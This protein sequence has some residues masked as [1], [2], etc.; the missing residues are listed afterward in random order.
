MG[1]TINALSLL[2]IVIWKLGPTR[3]PSLEFLFLIKLT[4]KHDSP[5]Q[6]PVTHQGLS[7]KL[8]TDAGWVA[9]R[10]A[11]R[12]GVL[13]KFSSVPAPRYIPPP[14]RGRYVT[15]LHS[16]APLRATDLIKNYKLIFCFPYLILCL[17]E[18][19]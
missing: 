7:F 4:W 1:F 5:W 18:G 3:Q 13:L 10:G 19:K 11:G 16:G 14:F 12:G 17:K 6:K 8:S 9:A 15:E 2:C